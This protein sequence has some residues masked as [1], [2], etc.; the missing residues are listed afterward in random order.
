VLK[1][2]YD[3][4]LIVKCFGSVQPDKDLEKEYHSA[5][6]LYPFC[7]F[8]SLEEAPL[9]WTYQRNAETNEVYER[10]E[11]LMTISSVSFLRYYPFELQLLNLKVGR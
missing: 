6:R 5:R 1:F 4:S 9:S 3:A 2:R 11:Y 8:N 7:V 10:C